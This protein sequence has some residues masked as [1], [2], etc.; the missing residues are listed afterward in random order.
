MASISCISCNAF[1]RRCNYI[2]EIRDAGTKKESFQSDFTTCLSEPMA[3]LRE[4]FGQLQMN[5]SSFQV[6][7][8]LHC[9]LVHGPLVAAS[10]YPFPCPLS[11]SMLRVNCSPP[12]VRGGTFWTFRSPRLLVHEHCN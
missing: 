6:V 12:T 1:I 9:H 8:Q 2:K 7:I 5:D 10:A 11:H 3:L 4:L